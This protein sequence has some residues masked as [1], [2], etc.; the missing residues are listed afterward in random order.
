MN[1]DVIFF[2]KLCEEFFNWCSQYFYLLL[3]SIE[4]IISL[5]VN[6]NY[7]YWHQL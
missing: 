5:C 4:I 6:N 7:L 2:I 1:H 3:I